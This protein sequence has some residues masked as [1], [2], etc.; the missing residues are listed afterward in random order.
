[1]KLAL[2]K[3]FNLFKSGKIQS[4]G[5]LK[6]KTVK[7]RWEMKINLEIKG[8]PDDKEI[9]PL[10]LIPFIENSFK[11]GINHQ[12]GEGFVNLLI[13][14]NHEDVTMTLKNSKSPSIPKINGKN[15]LYRVWANFYKRYSFRKNNRTF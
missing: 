8:E 13:N 1:M 2:G 7:E 3:I 5:N 12:V 6:L 4:L 15:V 11:H 10:L 14:I 9:A